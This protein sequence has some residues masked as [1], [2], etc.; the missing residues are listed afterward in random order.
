MWMPT[1]KSRGGRA[2][3]P[4]AKTENR[5]PFSEADWK[6][7]KVRKKPGAKLIGNRGGLAS[8]QTF[9]KGDTKQIVYAG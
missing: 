7:F 9:A 6:P 3:P 1:L 4:E 8:P 2:R 5:E